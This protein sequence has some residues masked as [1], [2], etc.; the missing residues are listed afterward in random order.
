[1][2]RL[3][4]HLLSGAKVQRKGLEAHAGE[5][6]V[7]F[8]GT[9]APVTYVIQGDPH[10]LRSG[11]LRLRGRVVTTPA[12]AAAAFRAI[13]ATLVLEGGAELRALMLAHT[14]GG[15]DVFVELRK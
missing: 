2:G 5:G 13:E 7:R 6:H 4:N 3:H 12:T 9:S 14:A 8:S 1:M 15:C 10:R 11:P